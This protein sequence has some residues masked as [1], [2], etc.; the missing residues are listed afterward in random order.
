[1]CWFMVQV[2]Y[3]WS[4]GVLEALEHGLETEGPP[5]EY[6]EWVVSA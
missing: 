1:M 2:E 3:C 4:I 6:L 5:Y